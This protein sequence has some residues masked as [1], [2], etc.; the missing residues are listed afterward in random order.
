MSQNLLQT[1]IQ[2]GALLSPSSYLLTLKD[3]ILYWE[4]EIDRI[5]IQIAATR[6]DRRD[7]VISKTD[8]RHKEYEMELLREDA[9]GHKEAYSMA[10]MLF[11]KYT[12]IRGEQ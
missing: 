12:E 3:S 6:Q 1:A 4:E 2:T 7:G 11:E 8:A 10:V 9:Y 5:N